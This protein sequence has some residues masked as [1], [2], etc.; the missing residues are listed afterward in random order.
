MSDARLNGN[1]VAVKPTVIVDTL[2]NV[3]SGLGTSRDKSVYT[4]WSLPVIPVPELE[5]AYR[6]DWIVRKIVD[7]PA[8]DATR[9]WRDWQAEDDQIEKIELTEEKFDL[10]NVV[11]SAIVK[12]RLYGGAAIVMGVEDGRPPEEELNVEKVGK[13][14]LKFLHVVPQHQMGASQINW[15]LM[16][17]YYMEPEYYQRTLPSGEMLRIHPSRVVRVI[18]CPF[19]DERNMVGSQW[20]DS[21]VSIVMDAVLTAGTAT[22]G[23]AAL[24]QEAKKDIIK[25]QDLSQHLSTQEYTNRLISRL[26]NMVLLKSITNA[27]VIDKE[28]EWEQMQVDF[29]TLPDIMKMYLLIAAGA[30][31]IPVTRMLGQSPAGMNATGESDI[32]NYYDRVR[33]DQNSELRPLLARRLD[34]VIVRSALG[35]YPPEIYYE[36]G[37]LWQ[38]TDVEKADLAAKK[39]STFKQDLDMGLINPDALRQVRINQLIEDGT[40]PGIEAAIEEFGEEPEE[41][42]DDEILAAFGE[43]QKRQK[44]VFPNAD[45]KV[46]PFKKKAFGDRYSDDLRF[47]DARPRTLYV[48]RNVINAKDIV[49]WAKAVGFETTLAPEDM[50]VTIAFSKQPLDWSKVG[51]DWHGDKHGRITVK[52]G[53]MRLVEI[54]GDAAK[55]AYVLLFSSYQLSARHSDIRDAGASW[56]WPDF[57]PHISI[58]YEMPADY[59]QPKYAGVIEPYRGEI[60]LGPE[61]FEELDEDWKSKVT[62]S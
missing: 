17:P 44:Q 25:F 51:E 48:R 23:V 62:E 61:I 15:D 52:P 57:Q 10:P 33:G 30:A 28:E 50:H 46:M 31:D 41:Q 32:R 29:G 9:E 16:S 3:V 34:Q 11:R 4:K 18:G 37:S 35:S 21:I 45:P 42:D 13:D 19:P 38:L 20:G 58:S 49:K 14:A 39:V 47:K 24:I 12:A 54:L 8:K 53:G 56:D 40:Y 6:G 55:P 43:L 27:T 36:W 26:Q 22:A 1:G 7:I 60:I 59:D 5:N 2:E